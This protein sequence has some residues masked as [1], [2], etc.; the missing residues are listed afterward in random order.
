MMVVCVG[1]TRRLQWS[2]KQDKPLG[3]LAC[4]HCGGRYTKPA[5]YIDYA[6][7]RVLER[8]ADDAARRIELAAARLERVMQECARMPRLL[9]E[10]RECLGQLH[11]RRVRLLPAINA[12]GAA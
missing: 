3:A 9:I 2:A 11:E 12:G 1:C 7:P 6:D 8:R 10:A 5:G 4:P